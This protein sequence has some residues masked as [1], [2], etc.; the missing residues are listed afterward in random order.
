MS[1][2][3]APAYFKNTHSVSLVIR[4]LAEAWCRKTMQPIYSGQCTKIWTGAWFTAEQRVL[5][6]CVCV[7][8]S[9][10][11]KSLHIGSNQ[12]SLL[13]ISHGSKMEWD[14]AK[15]TSKAQGICALKIWKFSRITSVLIK[16]LHISSINFVSFDIYTQLYAKEVIYN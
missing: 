6:V 3:T 16:F 4:T 13:L 11:S 9:P 15:Y 10:L 14:S 8:V 2:V 12:I 5:C 7:C 1:C